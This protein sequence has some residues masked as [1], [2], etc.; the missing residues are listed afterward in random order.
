MTEIIV[1]ATVAERAAGFAVREQVFIG[2]QGVPADMEYDALDDADSTDHF[3]ARVGGEAVGAARLTA[4]GGTAALGRLAVLPRARGAGLGA[5]LVRAVE[6]RARERGFT[7]V[8]LHAQVP[9]LE[10]YRALGYTAHGEEFEEAGIPHVEM[11]KEL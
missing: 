7:A 2:E 10:F 1:A 9:V 3:L 4:E 5:E 8:E 6:Q 11:R